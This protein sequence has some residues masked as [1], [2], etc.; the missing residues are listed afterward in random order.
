MKLLVLCEF[1]MYESTNNITNQSLENRVLNLINKGSEQLTKLIEADLLYRGLHNQ[2][3]T[4]GDN[5]D[6]IIKLI[7]SPPNVLFNLILPFLFSL[8]C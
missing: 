6:T 5:D 1:I 3:R 2:C 8:N 4:A 7:V